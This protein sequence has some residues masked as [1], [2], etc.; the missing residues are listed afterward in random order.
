MW[1]IIQLSQVTSYTHIHKQ[2]VHVHQNTLIS[3]NLKTENPNT[4]S[5]D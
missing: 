5:T 3:I 1:G 4:D 2:Y